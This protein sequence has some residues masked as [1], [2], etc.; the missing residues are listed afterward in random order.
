MYS[1]QSLPAVY[2]LLMVDIAARWNVKPEELL[3]DLGLTREMLLDPQRRISL[4]ILNQLLIKTQECTQKAELAILFGQEMQ[5]SMHGF[6]GFA[7]LT[8]ANVRQALSIAE[9]FVGM[10]SDIV[11][12]RLEE[13]DD[14]AILY[15]DVNTDLQP[16]RD[17]AVMAVIFGF[18]HMGH[19]A[20]GR[21]LSGRVEIDFPAP[22][23]LAPI[24]P[25]LP[26]EVR[27]EQPAN[28]IIFSKEYLDLPLMMANPIASQLALS[29]CEQGLEKFGLE[30]PF[31][32]QVKALMFD[33]RTGFA[34][35][36]HVASR[37]HMSERTLKRQL[38]KHSITYSDLVDESRKQKAMD[39]LSDKKQSLDDISEHLG[40]SDIANFTRAFKRWTG[41]TPS[42]FRKL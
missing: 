13:S 40:Y 36:E 10:I 23:Y 16:L 20:T 35:L 42:A 39:L 38:A 22:S 11:G 33:E 27:V 17:T 28:R 7:A 1:L 34:S 18:V 2:P 32:A 14:S 9:R 5:I 41:Q 29:Q 25:F 21:S 19:V 30:Q 12:I 37:L 3:G 24:L 26:G 15:L 31:V 6:I 8:A 4:D